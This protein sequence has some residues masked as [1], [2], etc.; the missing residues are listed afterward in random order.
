[1]CWQKWQYC[2]S[3]GSSHAA[4]L[5]SPRPPRCALTVKHELGVPVVGV[6]AVSVLL[7]SLAA[8]GTML[9][10]GKRS[11]YN[12]V[13][14]K[15]RLWRRCCMLLLLGGGRW[16][17]VAATT[18]NCLS[19]PTASTWA[20]DSSECLAM[21]AMCVASKTRMW[22]PLYIYC[23]VSAAFFCRVCSGCIHL[24]Y[25]MT[26]CALCM[27]LLAGAAAQQREC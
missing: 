26:M 23:A 11:I 2:V 15:C 19:V 7:V 22:R 12:E 1:M 9:G 3:G 14:S 24:R 13:S 6:P 17:V 5:P 10:T 16:E 4:P 18:A 27:F 20:A 25:S 21:R 8:P